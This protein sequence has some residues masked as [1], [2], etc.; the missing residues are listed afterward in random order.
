MSLDEF[1]IEQGDEGQFMWVLI[2]GEAKV[3]VNG[4]KVAGLKGNTA[5]G[6]A[7]LKHKAKRNASIIAE[8]QWK[9]LILEKDDYDR[10]IADT[11]KK[12][13]QQNLEFM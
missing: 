4:Q 8:S 1:I 3:D 11:D 13:K 12:Q 10:V 2:Y 7:A 9:V 6:E 5:F